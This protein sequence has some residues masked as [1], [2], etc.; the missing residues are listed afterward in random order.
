MPGLARGD[1]SMSDILTFAKTN[2]RGTEKTF[3]LLHRDRQFPTWLLGKTGRG[4]STVMEN[5]A[6]QD[7]R[8]GRCVFYVDPH[9]SSAKRLLEY[10]PKWR[11]RNTVYFCP[12]DIDY[13]LGL[14]LLENVNADTR[15]LVVSAI[16]STFKSLWEPY[17]LHLQ[18]QLLTMATASLLEAGGSYTLLDIPPLL[19]DAKF[20]A[21]VVERIQDPM[22]KQFW[23]HDFDAR[24]PEYRAESLAPILNKLSFFYMSRP[25]RHIIMQRRPKVSLE[26]VR[27]QNQIF[28]ANLAGIGRQEAILVANLL[29]AKLF[30]VASNVPESERTEIDFFADE[31]GLILGHMLEAYLSESRKLLLRLMLANQFTQ[32][33]GKLLPSFFGNVGNFIVFTLG[34]DDAEVLAPHVAP[35]FTAQDLQSL[36]AYEVIVRLSVNGQTSRPFFG[37]TLPPL[38]QAKNEGR[39]EHIIRNSRERFAMRAA[40]LSP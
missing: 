9:G 25:I 28:I 13:P 32:Q 6:I 5:V 39:S 14:N 40:A 1:M 3:G 2:W 18:E 17:F 23:E 10:V 16:V 27:E 20:R 12:S 24:K 19:T 36:S 4:K 38:R 34:A 15:H 8:A 26:Q 30:L 21:G 22:L 31:I 7:M 33:L 29:A 37:N 11:T 35:E